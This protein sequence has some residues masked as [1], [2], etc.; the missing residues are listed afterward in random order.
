MSHTILSTNEERDS[1][2]VA[3]GGTHL[4]VTAFAFLPVEH[5]QGTLIPRHRSSGQARYVTETQYTWE[6]QATLYWI[7]LQG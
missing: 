4:D 5:V 7:I 6:L 3:K 2:L 1:L